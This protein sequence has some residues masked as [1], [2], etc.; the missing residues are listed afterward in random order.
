[1]WR[2]RWMRVLLVMGAAASARRFEDKTVAPLRR[3]FFL[4]NDADAPAGVV[5]H[6]ITRT[7]H[8]RRER[9]PVIEGVPEVF[10][11]HLGSR[12]WVCVPALF[13]CF[14]APARNPA[15]EGQPLS[16]SFREPLW[17][18]YVRL[19]CCRERSGIA[20]RPSWHCNGDMKPATWPALTSLCGNG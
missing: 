17:F 19:A 3:G 16:G 5:P 13:I 6:L 1:M 2:L 14:K 7:P 11:V 15:T 8:H 12:P 20:K 18:W 9:F 4:A 10:K